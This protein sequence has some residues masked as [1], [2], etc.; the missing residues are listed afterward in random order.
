MAET[1]TPLN[2]LPPIPTEE[3]LLVLRGISESLVGELINRHTNPVRF[4]DDPEWAAQ[5]PSVTSYMG[6]SSKLWIPAFMTP[7]SLGANFSRNY[8]WE[9]EDS[10]FPSA[11]RTA[12]MI[13]V[14][15]E[16][17]LPWYTFTIQSGVKGHDGLQFWNRIWTGEE[18]RHAE[19]MRDYM[20]LGRVVDPRELELGRMRQLVTAEVP[21]PPS[22]VE[23][24]V[25]VTLQEL[26][27]RISHLN[28][29][30][31][32]SDTAK[33]DSEL[34]PLTA[35]GTALANV[36][37]EVIRGLTKEERII[38][39]RQTGRAI[40]NRIAGDENKHFAFYRELV[41]R[42]AIPINPSLVVRAIEKQVRA[43]QM[44]GTGIKE[45]K[46]QAL[47][48]AY[49]GV[50]DPEIHVNQ[51]IK[52]VL[53][54]WNFQELEGLDAEAEQSRDRTMAYIEDLQEKASTFIEKR[55]A[56]RE[57]SLEQGNTDDIWVGKQ[58][59]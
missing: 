24:A 49:A 13:G 56:R 27:T 50:Y 51:I 25:Y 28:T 15:T 38:Y 33:R 42:G 23:L 5:K 35:D 39:I 12:F 7:W 53:D 20:L 19:I 58:G 31:L 22:T 6:D 41:E 34:Y 18:D 3:D 59:A 29:G 36:D 17:N 57:K 40:M 44:P 16:E 37:D 54:R 32:V 47:E 21:E 10:P 1:L 43:F 48:L 52:P 4:K 45:F 26:A 8:V 46:R 11:A 55:D 2:E 9:P 14:L 30:K